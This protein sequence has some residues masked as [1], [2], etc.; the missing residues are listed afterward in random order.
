MA[1]G[2]SGGLQWGAI[3]SGHAMILGVLIV[4]SLLNVVYLLPIPFKAFF[5]PAPRLQSAGAAGV[6]LP[7]GLERKYWMVV[8]PPCL[9]AALCVVLFFQVDRILAL[10][11]PIVSQ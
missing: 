5:L 10:L 3:D 6:E 8:V 9:T 1:L 4:S 11:A 7:D 2:P